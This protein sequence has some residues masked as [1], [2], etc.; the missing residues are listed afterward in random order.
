VGEIEDEDDDATVVMSNCTKDK[1]ECDNINNLETELM[2]D[3][4]ASIEN[5]YQDIQ[6]GPPTAP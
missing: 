2:I 5:E 1:Q 3:D 6:R 4:D